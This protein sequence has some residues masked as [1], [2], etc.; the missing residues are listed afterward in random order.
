[1]G[2]NPGA[3]YLMECKRKVGKAKW[4]IPK[5]CLVIAVEATK[6]ILKDTLKAIAI[7]PLL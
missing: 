4:G 7:M 2:S 6:Q 1:M 3:G 5:K